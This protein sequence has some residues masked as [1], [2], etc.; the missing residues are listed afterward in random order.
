LL[1]PVP[2]QKDILP[3]LQGA[4]AGIGYPFVG[5]ADILAALQ[6]LCDG[7]LNFLNLF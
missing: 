6:N 4:Q 2:A 1:S 3:R 5:M 7:G